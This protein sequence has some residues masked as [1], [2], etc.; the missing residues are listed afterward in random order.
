M[1]EE[2]RLACRYRILRYVPNLIRD[3]WVNVGVLLEQMP[4]EG[5]AQT[6]VALRFIEENSEFAR[7]RR[8]HPEIDEDLLRSLPAEIERGLRGTGSDAAAYLGKLDQTLSNVLQFGPEKAVLTDDF[9]AELDRLYADQVSPPARKGHGVVQSGLDW[10]RTRLTD[11]FRRHRVL[12]RLERD[13]SVSGFTFSGDPMKIDY[14]Y[15]NG[16]RG[17]VHAVSLKRDLS[18]AKALAYTAGRVRQKAGKVEFTAMT[19]VEP[20]KGNESHEFVSQLFADQEIAIV[21]LSRAE[22]FAEN[23]RI[24]LS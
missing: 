23:L 20:L 7:V 8:V 9:R 12:G 21:P 11:I 5:A 17:F 4:D 16:A 2:L 14:A 13:V 3:E 22:G 6:R 19:E 24:R 18:R 15:Q 10:I 1:D